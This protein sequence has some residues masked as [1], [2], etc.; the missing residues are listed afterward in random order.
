[1]YVLVIIARSNV[2]D[3]IAHLT[4]NLEWHRLQ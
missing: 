2:L 4:Y 1:L 3:V